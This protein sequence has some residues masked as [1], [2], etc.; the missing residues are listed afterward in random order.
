MHKEKSEKSDSHLRT[1]WRRYAPMP[2]RRKIYNLRKKTKPARELNLISIVVPVYN[3]ERYIDDCVK[4]LV[5]QSYEKLEII[6][7]DDGSTDES[8]QMIAKWA[9]EDSRIRIIRQQNSGLSAA[10]NTGLKNARGEYV[11]FID[12][13]DTVPLDAVEAMARQLDSSGSDV[14]TGNVKR[15]KGDARWP[16]WNQSYSHDRANFPERTNDHVV[17]KIDVQDH[18]EILF[19]TTAWNKMFRRQFLLDNRIEFPVGKLYEDMHPMAQ[20]FMAAEGIDLIFDVVYN[21]RVREDKSSI[22]QKRSEIRNLRDKME[23]VDRIYELVGDSADAAHLRRTLEFKVFEG[24]LPVY[25]PYLGV[26]DEF[27]DLYYAYVQKYWN[28]TDVRTLNRTTLAK[29]A[30]LYWEYRRQGETGKAAANWVSENFFFI[31]IV[32]LNGTP[33]AD[34][35]EA[36]EA[37]RVL[38]EAGLADMSRYVAIRTTVTDAAISNGRL[39]VE[40]YAFLDELDSESITSRRFFLQGE[41]GSILDVDSQYVYNEWANDGWWNRAVDRNIE[42]FRIDC[43]L[44]ALFSGALT[45]KAQSLDGSAW[46]LCVEFK[47]SNEVKIG[48]VSNVWRG[49]SIRLGGVSELSDAMSA[50]LDWSDWRQPLTVRLRRDTT[51]VSA[52]VVDGQT[53]LLTIVHDLDYRNASVR[54]VVLKRIWDD[55]EVYGKLVDRGESESVYEF[56]LSDPADRS[57]AGGYLNAWRCLATDENGRWQVASAVETPSLTDI[58][59]L[60]WDIR[61]DSD[62]RALIVDPANSLLVDEIHFDDSSWRLSGRAPGYLESDAY[63][64]MWSDRGAS[65]PVE[66]RVQDG[67]FEIVVRPTNAGAWGG[68]DAWATGEYHFWLRS[69]GGDSRLRIR[70]SRAVLESDLPKNVWTELFHSRFHVSADNM[71]LSMRIGAPTVHAERG[72]LG[73][74][75]NLKSW[76]TVPD[77]DIK[78]LDAV[79]FSSFMSRNA[80]DSG[81]EIFREVQKLYPELECFWAVEDGSVSVPSGAT[82]LL[83]RT[84]KWFEVLSRARYVVN[85]V[86]AIEGY[87]DRVFQKFVQTWHGTPF[88]LVGKSQLRHDGFIHQIEEQKINDEAGTWDFFV[89]QNEFMGEV[90]ANDFGFRGDVLKAGYPRN[91]K[92]ATCTA[93]ERQ[94]IRERLGIAEGQIAVLYAPTWRESSANGRAAKLSNGFDIDKFSDTMG[95]EFTLLLRGHNY[96]AADSRKNRSARSILDVTHYR[97]VNELMIASDLLITDYSSIMF[98]YL[99]T[100]KPIVHFVTDLAE[101]TALRGTYFKLDEIAVGPIVQSEPALFDAISSHEVWFPEFLQKYGLMRDRFTPRDD[102]SAARR[103]TSLV[104]AKSALGS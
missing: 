6:L 47:Y 31:P 87:G 53:M 54:K 5:R 64:T 59:S 36:P 92:L 27:D 23:M 91:D 21:Y 2:I 12:S 101:Y 103:V 13:D 80:S 70:A 24:D 88:K 71:S 42:G 104:F 32:M 26:D 40:G 48:V 25:S 15:F 35:S 10:R 76:S 39:S 3:V 57:W 94:Q 81:L 99:V 45:E 50:R 17:E 22:T 79:V 65:Y 63:L 78:P 55:L 93:S 69:G 84:G 1:A 58:G 52:C 44:A 34:L 37:V 97:D 49:G 20:A 67:R 38:A 68:T 43:D 30:E 16:G 41:N 83:K 96:H 62:G 33:T 74:T 19:D 90:A 95:G 56:T 77:E 72:R 11:V 18:P 85:N 28:L 29:R 9:A 89:A 82:K 51:K 14:V 75:R 60:G 102:G 4:T 100:G 66:L 86:G 46:Q 61:T 73:L 8:S 7:V 98:D